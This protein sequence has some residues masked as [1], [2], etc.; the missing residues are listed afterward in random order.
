MLFIALGRTAIDT[1][2]GAAVADIVLGGGDHVMVSH[3]VVRSGFTL[4][5]F[6]HLASKSLHDAW[7]F[8]PGFISTAPAIIASYR[9]GGG[10]VPVQASYCQLTRCGPADF[11]Q[12]I[13]I[14][15]R[16]QTDIVREQGRADDVTHA[17][18][19]IRTPNNGN[20]GA[21]VGFIDRGVVIVVGH[22]DPVGNGGIFVAIRC[23]TAAI[24]DRSQVIVSDIVGGHF[25]DLGLENLADFFFQRHLCQ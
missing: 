11:L 9:N 2:Q 24:Q 7:I 10:E 23:R 3:E 12:Q 17:V 14:I 25:I 19:R 22:L 16:T 18:Y 6:N 21:A 13:W 1:I 20:T 5:T 4:Q 15:G 8:R